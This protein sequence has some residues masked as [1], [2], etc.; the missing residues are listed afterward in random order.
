MIACDA[1]V[2]QIDVG[3]GT[4][5]LQIYSG[6]KPVNLGDAIGA[7][8]K[9]AEFALPDP[10]FGNAVSTTGGGTATAD[11]AD[12]PT[13]TAPAGAGAGTVATWFRVIDGNGAPIMDGEVTDTAGVGPMKL[14]NTTVVANIDVTVVS[15]TCFHPE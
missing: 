15:W 12:I 10:C 5:L 11:V 7:Q 13:A 8:V 9:L 14:A 6:V 3:A 2:D 4:S 1:I